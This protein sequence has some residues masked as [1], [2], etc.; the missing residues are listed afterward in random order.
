LTGDEATVRWNGT[1]ADDEALVYL[2]QYSPD[3]GATWQTL[4]A[5]IT[6]TE[7]VVLLNEIAG[8]NSAL[9]RVMA[10]DGVN[11]GSD[12]SDGV[13]TVESKPPQAYIASP[14][15]LSSYDSGQQIVLAGEG[16]DVEE[17]LLAGSGLS[18][19]SDVQGFLGIGEHLAVTG[20]QAGR[21]VISLTATD[22][23]Q[24]EGSASVTV[25][26]DMSLVRMPLLRK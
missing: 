23:D 12:V 18:W 6:A 25:L 16:Y 3:A 7:H 2:L 13:F 8:S 1:D 11:T 20:L 19:S 17:G 10:S 26:V 15:D 4:A 24:M 14:D 22:S 5:E 21:H 9:F